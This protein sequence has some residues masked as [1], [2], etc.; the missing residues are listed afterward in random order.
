MDM[1][2]KA[3]SDGRDR[4][5]VTLSLFDRLGTSLGTWVGIL[6]LSGKVSQQ[7]TSKT[8]GLCQPGFGEDLGCT[9]SHSAPWWPQTVN[10]S[11]NQTVRLDPA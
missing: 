11:K 1:G 9:L 8:S 3:R 4:M 10:L 5:A 6:R 2:R 7:G